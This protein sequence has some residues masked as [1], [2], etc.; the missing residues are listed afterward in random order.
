[1]EVKTTGKLSSLVVN[2]V[3]ETFVAEGT[4]ESAGIN[5]HDALTFDL[6]N[7]RDGGLDDVVSVE[8]RS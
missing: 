4:A 1:M 6:E 2:E 3:K 8:A 5:M 7:L